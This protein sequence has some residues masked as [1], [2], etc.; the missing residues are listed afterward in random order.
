MKDKRMNSEE[1]EKTK[2]R[3]VG[4]LALVVLAVAVCAAV[5]TVAPFDRHDKIMQ[6]D[7]QQELAKQHADQIAQQQ[8]ALI[9]N[10]PG[11][12]WIKYVQPNLRPATI[13]DYSN[14]L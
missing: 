6:A 4:P 3:W 14:W 13:V 7:L 10:D 11:Q 1:K 5:V 9:E 12:Y 2:K 8:A